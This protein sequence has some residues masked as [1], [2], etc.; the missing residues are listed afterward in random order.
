MDT[1]LRSCCD[2]FRGSDIA[3]KPGRYRLIKSDASDVKRCIKNIFGTVGA[4][5]GNGADDM[6]T[7]V[8]DCRVDRLLAQKGNQ[9]F[10]N[11]NLSNRFRWTAPNG[12]DRPKGWSKL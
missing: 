8:H 3:K 2:S 7:G 4:L 1:R 5:V 12:A 10:C 11:Y 6:H 9:R